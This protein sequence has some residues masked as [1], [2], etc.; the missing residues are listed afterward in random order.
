MKDFFNKLLRRGLTQD[1]QLILSAHD[2]LKY[3]QGHL[4]ALA[5]LNFIKPERLVEEAENVKA[6]GEYLFKM[7]EAREKMK[8]PTGTKTS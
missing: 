4:I 2:G 5:R 3:L 8:K 1:Q 7:I 6:N